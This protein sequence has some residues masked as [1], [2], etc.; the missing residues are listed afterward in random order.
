MINIG[1]T[2]TGSLVGQAIIKSIKQCVNFNNSKI[3]GFDYVENT[4]GSYW[5]HKTFLLP[6]ILKKNVERNTW[7][8]EIV[9]I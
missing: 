2:G 1:V 3:I 4:V 5:C 8:N 7:I 6:D 9:K